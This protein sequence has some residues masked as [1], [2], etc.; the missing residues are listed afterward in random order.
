MMNDD[1]FTDN[2]NTLTKL[3]ERHSNN[4]ACLNECKG[5]FAARQAY[6]DEKMQPPSPKRPRRTYDDN[7]LEKLE[8]VF[9]TNSYPDRSYRNLL[10]KEMNV[11]P[12]NI[13]IWFQ[14]RRARERLLRRKAE[15][16]VENPIDRMR[17]QLIQ[18]PYPI[19]S[20][21]NQHGSEDNCENVK[22]TTQPGLMKYTFGKQKR[23][24]LQSI[25]YMQ[26]APQ[27]DCC[28]YLEKQEEQTMPVP[29][30]FDEQIQMETC[31]FG[32]NLTMQPQ[33]WQQLTQ[34]INKFSAVHSAGTSQGCFR[35]SLGSISNISDISNSSFSELVSALDSEDMSIEPSIRHFSPNLDF[36]FD[37]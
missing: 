31:N 19:H 13:Q 1:Q 3:T 6:D 37:Y 16:V 30:K 29:P 34:S 18:T 11:L 12:K 25:A 22:P 17:I 26:N 20:N 23:N 36:V 8:A 27:T 2:Y 10:A 21:G 14:N 4:S 15:G 32:F 7:E 28:K 5:L 35:V 9:A 24:P 33:P